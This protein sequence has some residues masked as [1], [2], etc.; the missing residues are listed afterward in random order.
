MSNSFL[1]CSLHPD[2]P[3][4]ISAMVENEGRRVSVPLCGDHPETV[5]VYPPMVAGET[6]YAEHRL[7]VIERRELMEPCC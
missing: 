4:A 2:R 7:V 3:A 6:S 1:V 5:L